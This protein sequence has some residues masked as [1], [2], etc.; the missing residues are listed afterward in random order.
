MGTLQVVSDTM[1]LRQK[2]AGLIDLEEKVS[3]TF[4]EE[5]RLLAIDFVATLP[6]VYGEELDRIK[7]WDRI[8]S[9]LR[10]S[11]AKVRSSSDAERY[12]SEVLEH[13]KAKGSDVARETRLGAVMLKLVEWEPENR[14]AWIQY[15]TNHIFVVL[16]FGKHEWERRKANN[17]N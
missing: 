13:V 1:I 4:N 15:I 8:E 9:A 5:C 2:L 14:I 6:A 3:P 12:I 16:S 11:A 17:G 7:L 10:T